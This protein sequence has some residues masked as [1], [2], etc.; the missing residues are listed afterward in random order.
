MNIKR[1]DGAVRTYS[2]EGPNGVECHYPS[3]TSLLQ[4]IGKPALMAWAKK[5]T[6]DWIYDNWESAKKLETMEEVG[7]FL[8][9]A[10]RAD[11]KV[12]DKAANVGT[13]AH[14][15][16][17]RY[18]RKQITL[19]QANP[20]VQHILQRFIEWEVETG[21]VMEQAERMV[22][23]HEY[24]YAGTLDISGIM[25][26]RG[27]VRA[28]VDIKTSNGIYPEAFLQVAAYAQAVAEMDGKPVDEGWIVR[29]DKTGA[30]FE[31]K[32]VPDLKACF[33]IFSA[34]YSL[35]RW[36]EDQKPKKEVKENA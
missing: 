9:E 23:S 17:E 11:I 28:I 10:K 20:A 8:K 26:K 35:W 30:E 6:C 19:D 15:E 27:N 3:V 36:L 24:Q 29:L 22:Y 32:Q 14:G 13:L 4:V 7:E 16:I 12:R 33:Q 2:V 18:L 21:F 5:M 1:N 34:T 31:T 25:T